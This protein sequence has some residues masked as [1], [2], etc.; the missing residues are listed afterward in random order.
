MYGEKRIMANVNL[1]VVPQVTMD[2]LVD[3]K[4]NGVGAVDR[5]IYYLKVAEDKEISCIPLGAPLEQGGVTKTIGI[6]LKRSEWDEEADMYWFVD[7]GYYL[8][9]DEQKAVLGL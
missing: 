3:A 9:S 8:F 6:Q 7:C 1:G 4:V 2:A 5:A